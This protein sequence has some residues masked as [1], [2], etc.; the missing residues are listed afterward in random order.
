MGG[1]G[2]THAKGIGVH[3]SMHTEPINFLIRILDLVKRTRH[4]RF[5]E[6]IVADILFEKGCYERALEVKRLSFF[7]FLTRLYI[8]HNA[9]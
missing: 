8:P 5:I 4:L 9:F 7:S 3:T 1:N 2:L 6:A